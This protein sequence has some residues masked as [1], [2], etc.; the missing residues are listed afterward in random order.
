METRVVP[1]PSRVNLPSPGPRSGGPRTGRWPAGPACSVER[2]RS[3]G[4][5]GACVGPPRIRQSSRVPGGWSSCSPSHTQGH[6]ISASVLLKQ[7]SPSGQGPGGGLRSGCLRPPWARAQAVK[8]TNRLLIDL[9]SLRARRFRFDSGQSLGNA[10]RLGRNNLTGAWTN[11]ESRRVKTAWVGVT[12]RCTPGL[13]N[14]FAASRPA[15]LTHPSSKRPL[16]PMKRSQGPSGRERPRWGSNP[17]HTGLESA[18]LPAE[19]REPFAV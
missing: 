5:L 18:A 19:L 14:A 2:V 15:A 16:G 13:A 4:A 11:W 10:R 17:R 8:A 6:S 7:H 1:K 9:P 12:G 3:A